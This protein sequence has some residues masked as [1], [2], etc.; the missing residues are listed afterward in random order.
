[1]HPRACFGQASAPGRG[2][3]PRQC[4][5][6]L[7]RTHCSRPPASPQPPR[8]SAAAPLRCRA[9]CPGGCPASPGSAAPGSPS[10]AQ[11]ARAAQHLAAV[12]LHCADHGTCSHCS[13]R[14]QAPSLPGLVLGGC[15]ALPGSAAPGSPSCGPYCAVLVG[16]IS[17]NRPILSRMAKEL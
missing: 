13:M 14:L 9:W 1:M 10:C 16:F 2:W 12:F 6:G 17:R 15:A 5:R 7:A 3:D 11:Q 8:S 4:A